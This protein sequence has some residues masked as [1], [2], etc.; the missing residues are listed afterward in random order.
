MIA[1]KRE[2]SR[3]AILMAVFA[4]VLIL[5][6]M[7][8]FNGKNALEYSDDLYNSISKQSAYYIPDTKEKV[9]AMESQR[10]TMNLEVGEDRA[11]ETARLF[12][13]AGA[14]VT[15]AGAILTVEGDLKSILLS[16]LEDAEA[17]F[18]ND[19]QALEKKYGYD[20]RPA[21]YNWWAACKVMDKNL[22]KQKLFKAAKL[23][24]TVNKKAV[25]PAYN[26]YGI[27]PQKLTER[28]GIVI[29]SLVFYV[30]YTL[31][32]GFGIMFLLEG[33]GMR[34]EH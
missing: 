10:V 34:L 21:L 15:T 5:M 26:Y 2:F 9:V 11:A 24:D 16:C 1:D 29:F 31:W 20:A 4:V 19:G 7:P 13:T 18:R 14:V 23:V 32:Y 28:L 30:I 12:R 8:L 6:F 3:G 25:E 33:W 22:T 27:E 17:M